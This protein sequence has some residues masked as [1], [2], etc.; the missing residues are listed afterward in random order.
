M[1]KYLSAILA[2]LLV[3]AIAVSAVAFV[4]KNDVSKTADQ[5]QNDL[6]ASK[7]DVEKLTADNAVANEALAAAKV[8][9]EKLTADN[10]VANEALAAAK[11]EVEKLTA[12]NAVANEALAAAKAEV[13]KLTAAPEAT[14]APVDEVP[15]EEEPV[16]EEPAEVA[17]ETT[18]FGDFTMV[19]G[20]NDVFQIAPQKTSNA[21][22]A[23]VY[24]NYDDTAESHSNI[25]V[26]WVNADAAGEINLYGVANYAA[27]IMQAAEQQYTAMGIKMTD[28]QVLSAVFENNTAIFVTSANLDYTG[29]GYD[30]VTPQCQIQAY[31]CKGDAGTYIFTC[32][33]TSMEDLQAM[34]AYLDTVQFK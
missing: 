5:L 25:N 6:T 24:P 21:V 9:V 17:A 10:T 3:A 18:D 20:A 2:V 34:S 28:A 22:H 19:L 31:F 23:I 4:Q 11:A 16:Q 1:K 12:D 13:E 7:A 14:A 32:T 30:L 29:A 15:V 33:A 8:E 26:V 27:L